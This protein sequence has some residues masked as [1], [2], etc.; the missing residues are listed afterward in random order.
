V[1]IVHPNGA[2]PK[3][4][5]DPEALRSALQNRR[6]RREIQPARTGCKD[7]RARRHRADP[8]CRLRPRYRRRR[9][10]AHLKPFYRRRRAVEAQVRGTGVGLGVVKH[11]VD[12]TPIAVD[13]HVG[14]GTT[15]TSTAAAGDQVARRGS[16]A[17]H[18]G[19]A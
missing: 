17:R 7:A 6:E 9:S 12:V 15:V 8:H 2:L 18:C 5:G 1:T 19:L 16:I 10:A 3:V 4:E 14:Q 11:I 13:S